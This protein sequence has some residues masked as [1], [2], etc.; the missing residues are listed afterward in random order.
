MTGA[1]HLIE[2]RTAWFL[3][4][5]A[6]APAGVWAWAKFRRT[7]CGRAAAFWRAVLAV[8]ATVIATWIALA[9]WIA[10]THPA[11][12]TAWTVLTLAGQVAWI[13]ARRMTSPSEKESA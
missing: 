1:V 11:L 3:A 13:A 10:P 8:F 9:V 2:P 6:T 7:A 12:F 4:A 5:L